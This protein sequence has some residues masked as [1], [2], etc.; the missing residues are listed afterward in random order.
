MVQRNGAVPRVLCQPY[1]QSDA[2]TGRMSTNAPQRQGGVP[3]GE[4]CSQLERLLESDARAEV[5]GQL[6]RGADASDALARLR[7]A[8]RSHRLP[9]SRAPVSI[10]GAVQSLDDRTKKEG[11]HVLESWDYRAQR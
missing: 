9:L 6:T 2:S 7:I 4:A 3:V 5:L 11:F 1:T 8:M 10:A